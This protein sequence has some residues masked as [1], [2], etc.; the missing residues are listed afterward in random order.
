MKILC[1]VIFLLMLGGIF[2]QNNRNAKP[3]GRTAKK[4]SSPTAEVGPDD[5]SVPSSGKDTR[6]GNQQAVS[7]NKVADDMKLHLL[8]NTPATCNDGT[9]AG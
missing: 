3:G 2:G 7:A 5:D 8:K 9:A 6:A 1:H 4:P